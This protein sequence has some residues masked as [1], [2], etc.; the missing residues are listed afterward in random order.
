MFNNYKFNEFPFNHYNGFLMTSLIIES[1][2]S[3]V[4]AEQHHICQSVNPFEI[5]TEFAQPEGVQ[6]HLNIEIDEFIIEHIF[7]KIF[8][9]AETGGFLFVTLT[10]ISKYIDYIKV[11]T[12]NQHRFNTLK[13]IEGIAP[14]AYSRA[15]IKMSI[16]P[17]QEAD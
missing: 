5:E 10:E 14:N 15:T 11:H 9:T 1:E 8:I 13:F 6:H 7:S 17:I 12:Y 2:F 16:Q 3:E 4:A